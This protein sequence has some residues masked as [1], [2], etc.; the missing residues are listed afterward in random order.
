MIRGRWA[1]GEIAKAIDKFYSKATLPEGS[2]VDDELSDLTDTIFELGWNEAK[3]AVEEFSKT[4]TR[5]P[6]IESFTS[7]VLSHLS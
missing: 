4:E 7:D 5:T 3:D 1:N 6:E 2:S